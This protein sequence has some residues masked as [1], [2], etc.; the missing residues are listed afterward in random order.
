MQK[1]VGKLLKK[2]DLFGESVSINYKGNST[3]T[4]KVGGLFGLVSIS[5]ILYFLYARTVKL[6]NRDDPSKY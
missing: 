4:T 2:F 1:R 6:F 3:Y 5:L